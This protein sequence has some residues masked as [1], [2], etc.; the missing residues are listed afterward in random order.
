MA[1]M[2]RTTIMADDALLDELRAIAKD[3]GVS[4]GE[5]IREALDHSA[6][7]M[8]SPVEYERPIHS[9]GTSRLTLC[10]PNGVKPSVGE[11]IDDFF[12]GNF[13]KGPKEARRCSPEAPPR[14][15]IKFARPEDERAEFV[16]MNAVIRH[17]VTDQVLAL[18]FCSVKPKTSHV[19]SRESSQFDRTFDVDRLVNG[20][21]QPSSNVRPIWVVQLGAA[22]EWRRG[23]FLVQRCRPHVD[24]PW[25][26]SNAQQ[27]FHAHPRVRRDAHRHGP[28]RYERHCCWL[29]VTRL[30]DRLTTGPSHARSSWALAYPRVVGRLVNRVGRNR[31][32]CS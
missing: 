26:C 29:V 32:R 25:H 19:V 31:P 14:H 18:G 28:R 15:A 24:H 22:A 2:S 7:G 3:E 20:C 6:L 21:A 11:G 5:V 1:R 9:D 30:S 10:P 4:L 17:K 23:R 16:P 12:G 8:I 27:L 13:V